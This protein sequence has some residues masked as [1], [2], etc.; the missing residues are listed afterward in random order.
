[1]TFP[2]GS[3]CFHNIMNV[4]KAIFINEA[5]SDFLKPKI[6]EEDLDNMTLLEIIKMVEGQSLITAEGY[7]GENRLGN[8]PNYVLKRLRTEGKL[9]ENSSH[10]IDTWDTYELWNVPGLESPWCVLDQNVKK[11][12]G[13]EHILKIVCFKAETYVR[14]EVDWSKTRE[15]KKP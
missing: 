10:I 12:R 6:T 1:M 3:S 9:L 11:T 5:L 14:H 15:L 7:G 8:I 13:G 4:M 2:I